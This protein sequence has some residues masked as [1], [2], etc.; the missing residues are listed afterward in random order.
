MQT[1]LVDAARFLELT[2]AVVANEAINSVIVATAR[3]LV[4]EPGVFDAEHHVIGEP[5]TAGMVV[6]R[7]RAALI[8]DVADSAAV[9]AIASLLASYPALDTIEAHHP[10]ARSIFSA[11]TATSGRRT[12]PDMA[13]GAFSLRDL[14]EPP[15]PRG[16]ARSATVADREVLI[17]WAIRFAV[18]ALGV[19]SPSGEETE[20][21]VDGRLDPDSDAGFFVWDV[22]GEIAAMAGHSG[23]T[24]T[25]IRV[26]LVYTPP[27]HRKRGFGTALCAAHGRHLLDSGYRNI[28]LFTDLANPTSNAMYERIG[29]RR[30]GTLERRSIDLVS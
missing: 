25:G 14:V 5:V 28:Y 9:E 8:T 13:M 24:G 22:D 4:S 19:E 11:Y 12:V 30:V 6:L 17:E 10:H 26:N 3:R 20:Q 21:L 15:S 27:G 18:E 7:E 2:P 16:M 29:Y 1:R 23:A